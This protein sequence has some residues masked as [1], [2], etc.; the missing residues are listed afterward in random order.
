VRHGFTSLRPPRGG[1]ACLERAVE[2]L[3][4]ALER[5]TTLP[6]AAPMDYIIETV[7]PTLGV[8]FS[9]SLYLAPLPAVFRAQRLDHIG[10]LNP[11]PLGLMLLSTIGWVAY[12][13]SA[14]NRYVVASNVIGVPLSVYYLATLLPLMREDPRSAQLKAVLVGGATF[15][16]AEMA[17]LA[18]AVAEEKRAGMMG[19]SAMVVCVLMF[20][21]PLSS[22]F[23]VIRSRSSASIYMPLTVVQIANCALW[24]FYGLAVGDIWVWGPNALGLLLG[25]CQAALIL[26]FPVRG[27]EEAMGIL[28]L[29][30]FPHSASWGNL[31]HAASWG[32][33]Q[34]VF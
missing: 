18:L 17:W 7:F 14:P 13:L 20:A 1:Q 10:E 21:A 6:H 22:L 5:A 32:N 23:Q 28:A 4:R 34:K 16:V 9:N 12:G 31:R 25:L 11:T 27:A 26:A 30:D 8:V 3:S 24:T 29:K 15:L 33:L 2:P 19:G